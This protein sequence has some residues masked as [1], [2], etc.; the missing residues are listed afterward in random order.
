M[1]RAAPSWR[2][3]ILSLLFAFSAI[4]A[5]AC[6]AADLAGGGSAAPGA[7]GKLAQE[8]RTLLELI[9]GY[10]QARGLGRL[11]WNDHLA[12]AARA[13]N[14]DMARHDYF[15]HCSPSGDCLPNRLAAAGYRYR[16]AAENL[17]AG[18]RTPLSVLRAWQNSP[19]HDENLL[20]G[21]MT[22]AGIDLDPRTVKGAQ[23]LWTLVL[24]QPAR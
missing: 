3:Y 20:A 18:Q 21:P 22:E 16:A 2:L 23:R 10:R 6:H 7:A 13:H 8:E 11:A 17:A 24:G 9:N 1:T 5:P 12:A 14:E 4:L 19:G 15:A